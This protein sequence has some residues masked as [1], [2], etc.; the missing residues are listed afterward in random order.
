MKEPQ[1]CLP[2]LTEV[3]LSWCRS[4]QLTGCSWNDFSDYWGLMLWSRRLKRSFNWNR[5]WPM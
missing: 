5:G 3:L 2:R 4:W 1:G